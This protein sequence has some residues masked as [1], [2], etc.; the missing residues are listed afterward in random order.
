MSSHEKSPE[1]VFGLSRLIDPV[2]P[3][4][5]LCDHW[6]QKPSTSSGMLR[7]TTATCSRSTTWT[8]S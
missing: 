2:E 5:F 6:E 7:T 1:A 8:S 4:A 3:K